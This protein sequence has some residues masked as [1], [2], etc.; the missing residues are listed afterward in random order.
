MGKGSFVPL[1]QG[2]Y[3]ALKWDFSRLRWL[4]CQQRLD[5]LHIGLCSS[6]YSS[7]SP[8]LTIPLTHHQKLLLCFVWCLSSMDSPPIGT[9]LSLALTPLW[10]SQMWL[11]AHLEHPVLCWSSQPVLAHLRIG[12]LRDVQAFNF[13][14]PEP[15]IN[16]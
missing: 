8:H 5:S 12:P 1:H 13:R 10:V 9:R 15:L 7:S 4:F 11:M 2:K 14:S 16:V 6:S 3:Q